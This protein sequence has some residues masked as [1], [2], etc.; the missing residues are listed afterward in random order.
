M[1]QALS[2]YVAASWGVVEALDWL[3]NRY[4]LP[5]ELVDASLAALI[6]MIPAV[7][8]VGSIILLISDMISQLPGSERLL[9]INSVTAL[10]SLVVDPTTSA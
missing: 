5:G 10:I 1:P 2:I 8:L 3:T 7:M 6:I 4:G 9:P